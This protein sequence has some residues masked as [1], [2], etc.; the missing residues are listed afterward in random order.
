[1]LQNAYIIHLLNNTNEKSLPN[2]LQRMNFQHSKR[3]SKLSLIVDFAFK[4]GSKTS[5]RLSNSS[6]RHRREKTKGRFGFSKVSLKTV[7]I[8]LTGN[9]YSNVE[10]VT[11]K[12]SIGISMG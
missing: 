10:N 6:T 4:V 2:L 5:T 8:H 1:M 9:C 3:K 11:M 7:T 12:Q